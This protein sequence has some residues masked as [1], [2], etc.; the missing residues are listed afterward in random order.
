MLPL[1]RDEQDWDSL[2]DELAALTD[3][4]VSAIS[5]ALQVNEPVGVV[6]RQYQFPD[7]KGELDAFVH[8]HG[9]EI[10][11]MYSVARHRDVPAYAGDDVQFALPI[12]HDGAEA[13][14]Q[15]ESLSASDLEDT[16]EQIVRHVD[17]A[18]FISQAVLNRMVDNG[19]LPAA[20]KHEM[21]DPLHGR[22]SP[23]QALGAIWDCLTNGLKLANRLHHANSHEAS[24]ALY[25]ECNRFEQLLADYGLEPDAAHLHARNLF[26]RF[27]DANGCQRTVLHDVLTA[28][29]RCADEPAPQEGSREYHAAMMRWR[30]AENI[31]NGDNEAQTRDDQALVRSSDDGYALLER[32][33]I[34]NLSRQPTLVIA[35]IRAYEAAALLA[36]ILQHEHPELEVDVD[37]SMVNLLTQQDQSIGLLRRST[38]ACFR[39]IG[40][41]LCCSL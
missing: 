14:E 12:L 36:A 24:L 25:E 38:A 10:E 15:T 20:M 35:R 11:V 9:D 41:M 29:E 19:L 16:R 1:P 39:F 5:K 13:G 4:S 21:P 27:L 34:V 18:E 32:G 6:L 31:R 33:E 23:E 26:T 22:A 3:R 37:A 2:V 17:M 40:A 28:D 30:D 8:S 7:L